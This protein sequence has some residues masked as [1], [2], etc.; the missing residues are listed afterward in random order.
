[1]VYS[2]R[3]IYRKYIIQ[4][5]K[6]KN[7]C[8]HTKFLDKILLSSIVFIT[9]LSH[10]KNLKQR[11]AFSSDVDIPQRS[12]TKRDIVWIGM[13]QVLWRQYSFLCCV[14]PSIRGKV[15]R[16]HRFLRAVIA[17]KQRIP[18]RAV[19]ISRLV[20]SQLYRFKCTV[21]NPTNFLL[22]L[23]IYRTAG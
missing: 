21:P 14:N 22:C 5:T 3:Q 1:M 10:A 19:R 23:R 17:E 2:Y 12:Q 7:V 20:P 18:P 13:L 8:I 4:I 9:T 6:K 11:T 16:Y 15:R